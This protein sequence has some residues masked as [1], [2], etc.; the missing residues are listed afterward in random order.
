MEQ[1]KFDKI[2]RVPRMKEYVRR[3]KSFQRGYEAAE[4][5]H[6]ETLKA[7]TEA[8]IKNEF[9]VICS[10]NLGRAKCKLQDELINYL[11]FKGIAATY[12]DIRFLTGKKEK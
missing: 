10:E 12:G 3:I 5:R 4:K 8:T 7:K 1:D 2:M 9:A 11:N 6:Q